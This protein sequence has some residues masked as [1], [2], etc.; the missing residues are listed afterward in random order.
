MNNRIPYSILKFSILSTI[1][2]IASA[3]AH[4]TNG[5]EFS[6]LRNSIVNVE[7]DDSKLSDYQ[8]M[9]YEKDA[10]RL[11]LRFISKG[12]DYEELD[13]DVPTEVMNEIYNSLLA[14]HRSPFN[15]ALDVTKNHRLHTFPK[16]AVD[17][18]QVNYNNTA[19]WATPLILGDN[20]TDS[21]L[22]NDLCA[23]YGLLIES[24]ERWD[25]EKNLFIVKAKKSLNIA[26]I[27]KKFKTENGVDIVNTLIPDTDGNDIEATRTKKGWKLDYIVKFDSCF[28][29]CKKKHIWS[30]EIANISSRSA[31]VNFLGEYGDD[32][33]DWMSGR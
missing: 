22:I 13:A 30:F 1:C 8:K 23:R 6:T 3:F 28:T 21:D 17:K 16:P 9:M 12:M 31:N 20:I 14:V 10:T 5:I 18:F 25:D 2:L 29:G 4:D 15:E 11:A 7:L 24:H 32:L 33:P 26:A 27:A 19:K